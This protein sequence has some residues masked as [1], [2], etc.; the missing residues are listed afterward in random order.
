LLE[1]RFE[2]ET[3]PVV[4]YRK[5]LLLIYSYLLG[6]RMKHRHIQTEENEWT[7]EVIHS[8]FE[9]GTDWDLVELLQIMR[10]NPKVAQLVREAVPHSK[11]YGIP[12]MFRLYLEKIY[13]C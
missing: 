4:V 12:E 9:R 3:V 2:V 8:Y 7:L 6:V 10:K 13:G 11:V 1:S 5:I